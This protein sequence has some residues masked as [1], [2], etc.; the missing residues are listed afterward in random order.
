M[1][2]QMHAQPAAALP[3]HLAVLP[4]QIFGRQLWY[5]SRLQVA[6]HAIGDKANDEVL[7]AFARAAESLNSTGTKVCA[8]LRHRVEHA[9]HLS[10]PDAIGGFKQ[11]GLTVVANPFHILTDKVPYA[12]AA[13]HVPCPAMSVC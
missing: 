10:G 12:C 1:L 3:Y 9:Q 4:C 6:V 2:M 13:I 8:G 11:A 5:H 7:A